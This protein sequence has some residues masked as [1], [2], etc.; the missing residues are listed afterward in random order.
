MPTSELQ[1]LRERHRR[2]LLKAAGAP[3]WVIEGKFP[4]LWERVPGEGPPWKVR[5]IRK[6][7]VNWKVVVD[8]CGNVL[9]RQ[10]WA[11]YRE[12]GYLSSSDIEDMGF[13]GLGV[14][15]GP[16]YEYEGEAEVIK[17]ISNFYPTYVEARGGWPLVGDHITVNTAD[18]PLRTRVAAIEG[19]MVVLPSG[20]QIT[21]ASIEKPEAMLR[22]QSPDRN[23]E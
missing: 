12:S 2:E 7:E 17:P 11:K 6:S 10:S 23:P 13:G 14:I 22:Y 19:G 21:P 8:E 1:Q 5:D 9:V 18:G 4:T 3:S 20:T 16:Q 15:P